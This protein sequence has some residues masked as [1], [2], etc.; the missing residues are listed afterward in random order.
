MQNNKDI[1]AREIARLAGPIM[2]S[3]NCVYICNYNSIM[4]LP[5]LCANG[6]AV[7]ETA[8][9]VNRRACKIVLNFAGQ[10]LKL[11]PQQLLVAWACL[12]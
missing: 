10:N 6:A 5:D 7:M 8:H 9:G 1:F 2:Q 3:S 4:H 11:C 12:H